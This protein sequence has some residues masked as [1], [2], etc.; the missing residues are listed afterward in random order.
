MLLVAGRGGRGRGGW[1]ERGQ[2]PTDS[3]IGHHYPA[4]SQPSGGGR[5]KYQQAGR[6]RRCPR[7]AAQTDVCGEAES[8]LKLEE[9]IKHP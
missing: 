4:S 6:L 7:L 3:I 2:Y 5:R 1:G 9:P 8:N